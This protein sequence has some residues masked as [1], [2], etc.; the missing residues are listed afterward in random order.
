MILLWASETGYLPGRF[1]KSADLMTVPV[2]FVISIAICIAGALLTLFLALFRSKGL[3][4]FDRFARRLP[5]GTLPILA[6]SVTASMVSAY[7]HNVFG[8]ETVDRR[9]F[10][11]RTV[12]SSALCRSIHDGVFRTGE[13]T[14]A[15]TGGTQVE[16]NGVSDRSDTLTVMWLDDCSYT[17]IG[18]GLQFGQQ[19]IIV[20][21]TDVLQTGTPA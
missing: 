11:E 1:A 16:Y 18:H 6:L 21:I 8:G 3:P 15:R 13:T 7:M 4:F 5:Y 2:T 12:P 14:I 9:E 17:L 10:D 19:R 20:H